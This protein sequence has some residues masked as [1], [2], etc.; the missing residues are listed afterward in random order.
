MFTHVFGED[1]ECERVRMCVDPVERVVDRVVTDDGQ[2]GAEDFFAHQQAFL[3]RIEHN[4]GRQDA[5]GAIRRRGMA[6]YFCAAKFGFGDGGGE[7]VES[8]FADHAGIVCAEIG[9][10]AASFAEQEFGKLD[11]TLAWGKHVIGR[12]AGLAGIDELAIADGLDRFLHRSGGTDHGRRLAAE[13]ERRRREVFCGGGSDTA[14]DGGR[15][16]EDEMVE[17]QA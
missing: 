14:A 13:F 5:A 9:I 10:G 2:Y 7:A 15:A 6:Q 12:D 17:W 4:D 1:V 8:A 3:R 11:H 16:S